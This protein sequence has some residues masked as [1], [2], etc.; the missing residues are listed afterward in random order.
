VIA[1]HRLSTVGQYTV[2]GEAHV[3]D[4]VPYGLFGPVQEYLDTTLPH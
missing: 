4:Y 2:A 1:P 3:P